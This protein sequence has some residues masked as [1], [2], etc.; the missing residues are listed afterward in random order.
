MGLFEEEEAEVE[1][2]NGADDT[3]DEE[4][5]DA[6]EMPINASVITS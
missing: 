5:E 4:N 2:E 1:R 6:G 3:A